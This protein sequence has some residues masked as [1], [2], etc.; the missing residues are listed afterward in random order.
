MGRTVRRSKPGSEPE[1][2]AEQNQDQAVAP[3]AEAPAPPSNGDGAHVDVRMRGTGAAV[4]KAASAF[5]EPPKLPEPAE[6]ESDPEMDRIMKLLSDYRNAVI[7]TRVDPQVWYG[8]KVDVRCGTRWQCPITIDRISEDVFG[9]YG[10]TRF[11]C[12]IIPNS[13]NG[14]LKPL[15]GFSVENPQD[16]PPMKE[17]VP[18]GPANAQGHPSIFQIPPTAHADPTMRDSDSPVALARA[19]IRRKIETTRDKAELRE[20][21]SALKELD[22]AN[23]APPAAKG[24]DPRDEEIKLLRDRLDGIEKGKS[25]DKWERRLESLTTLVEAQLKGGGKQ[26]GNNDITQVLLA[27]LASSD[28]RFNT[29]MTSFTQTLQANAGG[30]RAPDEDAVLDKLAKYKTLFGNE[31]DKS[32][33]LEDMAWEFLMERM[34]GGGGPAETEDTVQYAIKQLTPVL[35]TY[36]E[37]KID[38]DGKGAALTPEQYK[39]MVHEEAAK[40]SRAIVEDLQRKGYIVKA[41]GAKPAATPPKIGQTP[42]AGA[43]GEKSYPEEG[44]TKTVM[45]QPEDFSK[46]PPRPALAGEPPAQPAAEPAAQEEKPNMEKSVNLEGVGVVPLPVS[47][48][49]RSYD[50]AA[51]VNFV[52]DSITSEIV[53]R[54]PHDRPDDSLACG[55]MLDRLDDDLLEDLSKVENG[56]ALDKLLGEAGGD[57][58][59]I[60]RIKQM[61]RED[62]L[63]KTWLNRVIST[64]QEEYQRSV[65]EE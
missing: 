17:G 56:Q 21:L 53:Q 10:G 54:I 7:V 51:S 49:S 59:K 38:Q 29:M 61:G 6:P 47:P 46:A 3:A 58:A 65:T 40:Q 63:V 41:P 37:K 12:V 26:Q 60:E 55:D 11:N 39:K 18:I 34:S 50:R 16:E 32:K 30:R 42:K 43:P 2:G 62:P 4:R 13:P 52:L 20:A 35:K 25:D 14:E 64:V 45:I 48:Q 31:S 23:A 36:V 57:Q 44:T 1:P 33:R 9:R 22:E 8:Q 5:A 19:A 28:T 27:Q 24:P 15:G